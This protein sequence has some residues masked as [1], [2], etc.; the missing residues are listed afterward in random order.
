VQSYLDRLRF[1][2]D[3]PAMYGA[4]VRASSLLLGLQSSWAA[5][6]GIRHLAIKVRMLLLLLLLLQSA[7]NPQG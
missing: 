2:P 4:V 5:T 3:L 1:T 7:V 6:S